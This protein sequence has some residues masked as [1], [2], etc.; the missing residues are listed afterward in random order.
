MPS[1]AFLGRDSVSGFVRIAYVAVP[2]THFLGRCACLA[3][4]V[5]AAAD[6]GSRRTP[7]AGL[8]AREVQG[9]FASTNVFIVQLSGVA[10]EGVA[11]ACV[12]VARQM[13]EKGG[14]GGISGLSE[15]TNTPYSFV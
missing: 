1:L 9:A 2:H 3:T 7:V 10:L 14:A 13:A 4:V 15:F 11:V 5:N 12:A 6:A 8:V